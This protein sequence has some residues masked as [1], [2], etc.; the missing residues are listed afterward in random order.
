M[1]IDLNDRAAVTRLDP[2][3]MMAF[4]E[5]FPAQCRQALSI[6]QSVELAPLHP[7][8]N[9]VV[10]TGLGGS[11]AGGDLV[12]ALFEESAAVPFLVNRDYHLPNY[13]GLGDLV[14]CSSYSGNTEETLSAYD[15]AKGRGAR[16]VCVT[17]G[18][19][20][21]EQA[22]ADGNPVFVVPG[23][24]PPRTALGFM[25]IP[26]VAACER[27]GLIPPIDYET[28]FSTLERCAEAWGVEGGDDEAKRLAQALHGKVGVLYGLGLWQGLV[29]NRWKGQINEN[30]KNMAFANSYPE[31]NH[32]E[33]LGWVK[34]DEQG[35]R[36][37]VGIL[38]SGGDESAK[39]R[40]RAEVTERIVADRA[41]FHE[42]RAPGDSPFERLLAVTYLGDFVSLYLAA[43]NEVDPENIDAINELKS[44]LAKVN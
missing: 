5:A 18:G 22:D 42:V 2:K 17:S 31:L 4:T 9:L 8:P 24:Q 1:P 21:K 20:L 23:G 38:I 32:N 37:W 36:E 25:L 41:R 33:I 6:A 7:D 15:D 35:V 19:R 28:A 3:G 14:F 43:L 12:R 11:A 13:V 10:L 40:K 44:E 16:I 34:A 30:A 39:M 27:Y 29:A 26:I